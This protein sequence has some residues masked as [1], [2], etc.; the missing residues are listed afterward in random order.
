MQSS[1]SWVFNIF[2]IITLSFFSVFIC[3]IAQCQT[4]F[5]K[6]IEIIKMLDKLQLIKKFESFT[7][8]SN[9]MEIEIEDMEIT[10]D[11]Q[12]LFHLRIPKKTVEHCEIELITWK[13]RLE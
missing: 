11:G 2:L 5:I 3:V 1:N 7:V 13:I 4:L 12:T 8:K 6:S 10:I 9:E